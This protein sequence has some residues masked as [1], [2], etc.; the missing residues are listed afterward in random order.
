MGKDSEL[1]S[2]NNS[3]DGQPVRAAEENNHPVSKLE[4]SIVVPIACPEP[5]VLL[6]QMSG[7]EYNQRVQRGAAVFD[8][9]AERKKLSTMFH[10]NDQTNPSQAL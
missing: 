2:S 6:M 1:G 8:K 5:V 9:S 4:Y 7:R 3:A 10:K